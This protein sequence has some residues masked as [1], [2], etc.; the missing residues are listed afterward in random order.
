MFQTASK[1]CDWVPDSCRPE[2]ERDTLHSWETVWL[3]E[4]YDLDPEKGWVFN[5]D[6]FEWATKSKPVLK[7]LSLSLEQ[8]PKAVPGSQ[9]LGLE[10]PSPL[11]IPS[12]G[13]HISFG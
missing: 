12:L 1:I 8:R 6:R 3:I 13:K 7:T 10:I 2:S 9:Y 11:L 4:H 5:R